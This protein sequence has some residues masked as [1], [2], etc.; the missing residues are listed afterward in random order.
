MCIG[1][2]VCKDNDYVCISCATDLISKSIPTKVLSVEFTITSVVENAFKLDRRIKSR[3]PNSRY[4]SLLGPAK[5]QNLLVEIRVYTGGAACIGHYTL[6][7]GTWISHV[8]IG[9]GVTETAAVD[10]SMAEGIT[11]PPFTQ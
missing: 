6:Q 8:P 9:V 3:F 10:D 1:K 4:G 5:F 7:N 2:S 11:Q